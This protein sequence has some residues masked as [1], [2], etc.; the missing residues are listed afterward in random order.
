M[1]FKLSKLYHFVN[2]KL[3]CYNWFQNSFPSK[4]DLLRS[5]CNKLMFF[6]FVFF[7]GQNYI[8]QSVNLI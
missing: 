2:V 4:L 8:K 3:V 5:R 6:L 7:C 1:S